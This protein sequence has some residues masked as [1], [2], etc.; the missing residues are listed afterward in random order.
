MFLFQTRYDIPMPPNYTYNVM[1]EPQGKKYEVVCQPVHS[2]QN[3]EADRILIRVGC[4]RSATHTFRI[5]WRLSGGREMVSG[6]IKLHHFVPSR[7]TRQSKKRVEIG[8]VEEARSPP[9]GEQMGCVEASI[10]TAMQ[11]S[12]AVARARFC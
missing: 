11:V 6:P 8:Q 5:K 4:P 7:R 9:P 10:R 12:A 3:G 2:L 1:L